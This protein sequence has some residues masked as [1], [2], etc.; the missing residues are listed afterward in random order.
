VYLTSCV[1]ACSYT[2]YTT[3]GIRGVG[4]AYGYQLLFSPEQGLLT[5]AL[6]QSGD[7][8]AAYAVA[9]AVV[10]RYCAEGAVL[11]EV[12]LEAARSSVMFAHI[13][14]VLTSCITATISHWLH[15]SVVFANFM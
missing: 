11:D 14:Q 10:Q 4:L 6:Y 3:A 9:A 2:N 15:C 12:A 1:H 8:A 13:E 5:F 7:V